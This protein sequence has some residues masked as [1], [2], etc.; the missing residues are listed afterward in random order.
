[1][2][3]ILDSSF[4]YTPS[5]NTDVRETFRRIR[6]EQEARMRA[7]EQAEIPQNQQAGANSSG[8]QHRG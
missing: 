8:G 7:Q 1:M 2:K 5:S 3:S 4:K 6:R